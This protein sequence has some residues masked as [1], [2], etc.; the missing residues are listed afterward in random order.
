ME[1]KCVLIESK[2][3]PLAARPETVVDINDKIDLCKNLAHSCRRLAPLLGIRPVYLYHQGSKHRRTGWHFN[4]FDP[5]MLRQIQILDTAPYIKGNR[6]AG[7]LAVRFGHK[8]DH[9]IA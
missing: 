7:A 9:Q 5:R 8:I 3:D 4:Q 2:A 1:F 6:M